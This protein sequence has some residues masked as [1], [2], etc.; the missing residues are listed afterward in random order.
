MSL[1]VHANLKMRPP[2]ETKVVQPHI[3]SLFRSAGCQA[4]STSQYRASHIVQGFPD[5]VV[6]A[7]AILKMFFFE[8]KSYLAEWTNDRGVRI[9]FNPFDEATWHPK[10]LEP[11]QVR[12]RERILTCGQLHYWGG[13]PEARATLVELGLAHRGERGTF[14]LGRPR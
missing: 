2:S 1:H 10:P 14:Y 3:V 11:A 13:V 4:D 12:F 5:L 8:V 9:R 7:P 6:F